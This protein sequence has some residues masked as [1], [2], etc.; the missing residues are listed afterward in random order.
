MMASLDFTVAWS[1]EVPVEILG[2]HL[3]AY[4]ELQPTIQALRL[5]NRYGQGFRAAVTK[6]P[7]ELVKEIEGHLIIDERKKQRKN[8]ATDFRCFQ[9]LCKPLEHLSDSKQVDIWRDIRYTCG[10]L[11]CMDSDDEED[12]DEKACLHVVPT[13][14]LNA[15][16]QKTLEEFLDSVGAGEDEEDSLWW[17]EHESRCSRWHGKTGSPIDPMRGLLSDFAKTLLRN[18]GLELWVTHTQSPKGKPGQFRV[19]G[20]Y[21]S[22]IVFL[23]LPHA[24]TRKSIDRGRRAFANLNTYEVP[25]V[26]TEG[27]GAAFMEMPK[28]LSTTD[29]TRF[30]R[31]VSI[32]GLIPQI[33]DEENEDATSGIEEESNV[34]RDENEDSGKRD[35]PVQMGPKLAVLYRQAV[36]EEY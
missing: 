24:K 31:A 9:G 11:T 15:R 32:L 28:A 35:A 14:K 6:L 36:D 1:L 22:T 23:T 27:G 16:Q 5:C 3:Q 34:E 12:G 20:V 33:D 21:A 8:W 26:A 30:S 7:I 2:A 4:V 19:V 18:F 10:C 13:D 29:S 25:F 17:M